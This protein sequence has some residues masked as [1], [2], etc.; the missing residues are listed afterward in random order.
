MY[1]KALI[2]ILLLIAIVVDVNAQGCS[3]CKAVAADGVRDNQNT[4]GLGLNNGILYLMAIPYI[5]LFFLF[6][7]KIVSFYREFMSMNK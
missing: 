3:M 5:I 7:K 4:V 6:R 2:V 1:K